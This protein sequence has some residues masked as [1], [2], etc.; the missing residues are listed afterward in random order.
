MVFVLILLRTGL[1]FVVARRGQG[2]GVSFRTN[3][4]LL[5]EPAWWMEHWSEAGLELEGVFVKYQFG[6][7]GSCG[8]I[9]AE[10]AI[11]YCRLVQFPQ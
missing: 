3:C 1:V 8:G 5:V 7:R 4:F 6:A 9:M 2:K 11:Q 10:G